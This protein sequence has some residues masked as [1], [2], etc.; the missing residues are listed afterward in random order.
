MVLQTAKMVRGR[1]LMRWILLLF[2]TLLYGIDCARPENSAEQAVCTR[3][4]LR[5]KDQDIERQS[6][7]LKAKLLG[8][9]AAI[10]ADTEMPFLRQRDDCSN[11]SDVPAC[12]AKTLSARQDLLTRTQADPNAIREAIAQVRYIDIGFLWKYW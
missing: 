6:K 3:P 11:E 7:A 2:P 4:D 12:L 10:L 1:H 5:A 8:E 9:N